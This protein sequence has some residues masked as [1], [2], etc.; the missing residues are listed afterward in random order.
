MVTC[1][2]EYSVVRDFDHVTNHYIYS[3]PITKWAIPGWTI[4]RLNV[5]DHPGFMRYL[6]LDDWYCVVHILEFMRVN[7]VA[8]SLGVFSPFFLCN[9]QYIFA[10]SIFSLASLT[11]KMG[12]TLHGNVSFVGYIVA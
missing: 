8:F 11:K 12:Y 7:L 1:H 4:C 10:G 6:V 3:M 5:Y 2:D 9:S